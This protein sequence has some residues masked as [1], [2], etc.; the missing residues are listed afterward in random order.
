MDRR[1]S[2]MWCEMTKSEDQ[3]SGRLVATELMG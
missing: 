2:V 1:R 3:V